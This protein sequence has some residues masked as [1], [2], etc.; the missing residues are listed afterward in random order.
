MTEKLITPIDETTGVPLPI[1]PNPHL[2]PVIHLPAKNYELRGDWHHPFHPREALVKGSL[3][4]QA[5]RNCRVQWTEYRE[6]HDGVGYHET[7]AGPPLPESEEDIFKTVV[8][9]AAKFLPD[10]ALAFGGDGQASV[11]RLDDIGR[12]MLLQDGIIKVPNRIAVRDFL[13]DYL[14]RNGGLREEQGKMV[15][16]FL[17]AEGREDKQLLGR[18]LINL[19]S[20]AATATIEPAY[21]RARSSHKLPARRTA[22]PDAFVSNFLLMVRHNEDARSIQMFEKSLRLAS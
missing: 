19:A 6:H 12:H 15:E 9:A 11:V 8:F 5:L 21:R 2:P 4:Q 16:K 22:K 13:L 14:A 1:Y 7:F 18:M 17:D 20:R 3:G 10:R